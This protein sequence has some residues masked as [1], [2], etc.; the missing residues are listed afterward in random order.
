MKAAAADRWEE[1]DACR[2]GEEW[3][4]EA[5]AH[6]PSD[7]HSPKKRRR[8]TV[9]TGCPTSDNLAGSG[10]AGIPLARSSALKTL[11]EAVVARRD[12]EIIEYSDEWL[13][14]LVRDLAKFND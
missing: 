7:W 12:T 5:H 4:A 2:L 1:V 8:F 3:S 13:D 9:V 6:R 10:H 11:A 14:S